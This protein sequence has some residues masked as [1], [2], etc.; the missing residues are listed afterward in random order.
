MQ[1]KEHTAMTKREPA[2][3]SRRIRVTAALAAALSFVAPAAMA[4]EGR[5]DPPGQRDANHCVAD[6][7]GVDFNELFG[8]S[9]QIINRFCLEATAGERWRTMIPWIVSP[10]EGAVYPDGYTPLQAAPIDD[11]EAKVEYVKVIVDGGTRHERVLLF[12]GEE[13][14]R[15]GFTFDQLEPGAPPLP[16]TVVLTPPLHPLSKGE[17]TRELI[18]SLS[19]MHCDG[20]SPDAELNCLPAGETTLFPRPINVVNP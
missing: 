10:E 15:S 17:H 16:T 1:P 4:S 8:V 18:F 3:V 7:T 6:E 5:T 12:S 20:L 13:G 9:E 14:L 2:A 19:A 11:F